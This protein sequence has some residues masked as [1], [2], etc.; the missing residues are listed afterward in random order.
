MTNESKKGLV[1]NKVCDIFPE[2]ENIIV[3]PHIVQTAINKLKSEKSCGN[4]G[5]SGEHFKNSHDRLSVLLALFYSSA[6]SHGYIPA[7]FMKT[8]IVPLVKNKSGDICD[9][10]NYRPIALVT[11]AS[12]IFEIILLEYME[13]YLYTSNNQ[14]GFKKGHGTDHCIFVY[15]NVIDFYRSHNSPV[16][17][18]LLDASRAFDRVN[19]WSLFSKLVDRGVPLIIIRILV[20]W[21]RTQTFC[22][23]WGSVSSSFFSVSNGVRQ[24]GI[25]SPYLFVLYVD[26]L[27]DLLNSSGA[28]C[29]VNNSCVNLIFYAD[30][31][32]LMAPSPS[33]L[34]RLV[35]A[36]ALYGIDNDIIYNIKKTF[37]MIFKPHRYQLSCPD[38]Y[39]LYIL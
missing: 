35:D 24:G 13:D 5:L 33:G 25:L 12:K 26:G 29:H 10:S 4:D 19:H 23:K 18:C 32:C 11:V 37:C 38:I 28:G 2:H 15:K 31:F 22:V 8:I 17:T 7:D 36:C 30:D 20:Y 34:Q 3:L 21:Y 39:I 27:S 14:F 16:Y 6:L 9:V 1:Q